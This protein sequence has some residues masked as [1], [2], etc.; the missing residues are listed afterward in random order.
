MYL[1]VEGVLSSA[2]GRVNE[3]KRGWPA[4][5][6]EEELDVKGALVLHG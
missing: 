4:Y 5:M 2:A 3:L 1:W 6:G